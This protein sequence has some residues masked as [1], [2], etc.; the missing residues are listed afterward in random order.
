MSS[1]FANLS[2]ELAL[3]ILEQLTWDSNAT[4]SV[5]LNCLLSSKILHALASRILYRD[6]VLTQEKLSSFVRQRRSD[7]PTTT[8]GLLRTLTIR[9][10]PRTTNQ[11]DTLADLKELGLRHLP[12]MNNLMCL[13][14]Y[15]LPV[16]SVSGIDFTVPPEGLAE[17]LRNLPASCT[18]LE[19][20]SIKIESS[21][22]LGTVESQLTCSNSIHLCP[23]LRQVLPRLEYVRIRLPA[24]CDKIF[25]GTDTGDESFDTIY[26]WKECTINVARKWGPCRGPTGPNNSLLCFDP[27]Q[28]TLPILTRALRSLLEKQKVPL[29]DK[30]WILEF[31]SHPQEPRNPNKYAAFVV[32]D[33]LSQMSLALPHRDVHAL[34]Q[35]TWHLRRPIPGSR[36]VYKD[37]QVEWQW[38]DA[39]GW[40][41]DIEQ[42]AEGPS[43]QEVAASNAVRGVRVPSS[44]AKS[45][46]G[47]RY[48]AIDLPV[49][50]AEEFYNKRKINSVLWANEKK[51]GELLLTPA[52]KDLM[53]VHADL[54]MV[55][56]K[57]WQKP[58]DGAPLLVKVGNVLNNT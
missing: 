41:Y 49:L 53:A 9:L 15:Q 14:V 48:K 28:S 45:S 26:H 7:P 24:L 50:S 38:E 3:R 19:L 35:D 21:S 34:A 4:S 13:S 52:E 33:V 5:L 10:N 29:A 16:P 17:I 12:L 47:Q 51:V 22:N 54:D 46:R 27:T 6:V 2:P 30:V 56:P 18:S 58:D 43:W 57:G 8:N 31:Q 55:I 36:T 39:V 37:H 42:L 44:F 32:R 25:E 11:Q 40:S 1:P 23:L 20:Q